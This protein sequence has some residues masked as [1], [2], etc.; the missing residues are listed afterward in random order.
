MD[1]PWWRRKPRPKHALP[2]PWY[3]RKLVWAG[4]GAVTIA[5]V[6]FVVRSFAGGG[7]PFVEPDF[8]TT[9]TAPPTTTTTTTTTTTRPTTTTTTTPAVEC[10]D[11]T[12]PSLLATIDATTASAVAL[13]DG[14]FV[15]KADGAT[16][17][18]TADPTTDSAGEVVPMN[19]PAR[20]DS[21]SHRDV[22]PGDPL[23]NGHTD[24]EPEAAASRGCAPTA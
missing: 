19:E 14:W 6:I 11:V 16:W 12:N 18:T 13:D 17:Y 7:T 1:R 22:Q 2:T 23:Y 21:D 10:I 20:Q 4:G 24:D 15:S 8:N 5:V 3:Q 9:S